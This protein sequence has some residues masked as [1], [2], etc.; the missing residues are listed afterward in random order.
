MRINNQMKAPQRMNKFNITP[1]KFV[2]GMIIITLFYL[3]NHPA[4]AQHGS[5]TRSVEMRPGTQAPNLPTK[6]SIPDFSENKNKPDTKDMNAAVL[7]HQE[8]VQLKKSRWSKPKVDP[9]PN[10]SASPILQR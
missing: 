10:P 3:Q 7:N 1:Q 6:K 5:G 4:W 9:T 8:K 2:M